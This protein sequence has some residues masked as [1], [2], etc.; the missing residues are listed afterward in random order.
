MNVWPAFTFPV[1]T[2]GF[3]ISYMTVSQEP[4]PWSRGIQET[5]NSVS[6]YIPLHDRLCIS[7][8]SYFEGK[9]GTEHAVSVGLVPYRTW[10]DMIKKVG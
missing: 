5:W 3:L 2:T 4:D 1:G 10:H 9:Y 8:L 7:L 6:F